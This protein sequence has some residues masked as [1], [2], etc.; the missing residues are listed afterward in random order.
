MRTR[1]KICGLTSSADAREAARLGADAV[2][3]NFYPKS[4]RCIPKETAR[5]ILQALPAFVEPAA[6]FVNESWATITTFLQ[7]LPG[8]VTVQIHGD[9]ILPCPAYLP[10]RWIP[11]F[12]VGDEQTLRL[13]AAFVKSCA[14]PPAAVLLDAHVPGSYGGTGQTAP[15]DLLVGFDPGVPVLL[16]GGL[17][18]LNV[19]AAIQRVRPYGVDVASGVETS[20]G[21]KDPA[22]LAAFLAEVAQAD[23]RG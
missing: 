16:A 20:P 6:L 4:P 17:T 7:D 22:K 3:L 8:V 15:W 5:D 1:V 21:R 2:G 14:H 13:I 23:A 9:E 19:G 18:P 11:A 12:P 10:F